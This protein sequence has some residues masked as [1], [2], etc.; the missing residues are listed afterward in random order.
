MATASFQRSLPSRVEPL[1]L[2]HPPGAEL[3]L[4]ADGQLSELAAE[5]PGSP[6]STE[7][8]LGRAPGGALDRRR[9][10]GS[11]SAFSLSTDV[12]TPARA[13]EERL[14]HGGPGSLLLS[15]RQLLRPRA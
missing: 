9:D 15:L 7:A 1:E 6:L 10:G 8:C 12:S 5:S 13:F 3:A 11:T 2:G 4:G 14:V